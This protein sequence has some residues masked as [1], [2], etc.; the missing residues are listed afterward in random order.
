MWFR[1]SYQWDD[2]ECD[3]WY[4]V[5]SQ[6]SN[7]SSFYEVLIASRSSIRVLIGKCTLGLFACLPDHQASC[8][9]SELRDTFYNSE[10][11][12]YVMDNPVDGTTVACALNALADVLKFS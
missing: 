12:I 3:N 5:V 2:D 10:K 11:L 7:F 6:I 1:C 4:G 8:Y 9:L